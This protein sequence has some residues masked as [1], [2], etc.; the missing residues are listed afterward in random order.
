M[1][2]KIILTQSNNESVTNSV[3]TKIYKMIEKENK[4]QENEFTN[5]STMTGNLILSGATY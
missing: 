3:I 1:E 5:D 4:Y 2:K